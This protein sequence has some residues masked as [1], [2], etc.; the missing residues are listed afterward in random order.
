MNKKVLSLLIASGLM[1]SCL[2]GC[3]SSDGSAKTT[4][5]TTQESETPAEEAGS[6]GE[7]PT[8]EEDPYG[9]VSDEVVEIHMG[10][11][12]DPTA[13]YLEGDSIED[14][15]LIRYLEEKLNVDYVF[16]FVAETD[17]EQ[18]VA[19]AIASDSLPE[20]CMVNMIQFRELAEAGAIE[21]L[22]DAFNTYAS[23][24][25]R[26]LIDITEG[27][28]QDVVTVD[29]KI[30]GVAEMSQNKMSAVPITYIRK[31]WME[32]LGL[33]EPKTMADVVDI[34][35]AFM[36]KNPGG[37]VTD[38][39]IA[40]NEI[41]IANG[42]YR[43]NGFFDVFG[44]YPETWIPQDDGTV[45]W[46]GVTEETKAALANLAGLVE[47]GVLDGALAVRDDTQCQEMLY[48]GRAG[49]WCGS[50]WSNSVFADMYAQEGSAA[51]FAA[52]TMFGEDGKVTVA[53][54]RPFEENIIV[55]KK[56]ASED[57]KEA[58]I[59]TVNYETEIMRTD[60]YAVRN[61]LGLDVPFFHGCM[62]FQMTF[63]PYNLTY[64]TGQAAMDTLSGDMA[65]DEFYANYSAGSVFYEG[66]KYVEEVGGIVNAT[67]AAKTFGYTFSEPIFECIETQDDVSIFFPPAA[68]YGMTD[69]YAELWPQLEDMQDEFFLQ[70]ITGEVSI[71]E[72]DSFVEKWYAQGGEVITQEYNDLI[73]G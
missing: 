19:M 54:T 11:R 68:T 14:N 31:D 21:D 1:M 23:E 27:V 10:R 7:I 8:G 40:S 15:Y 44:S 64:I 38:G 67:D 35:R 18:K 53:A 60:G 6:T 59:K 33:E 36:E 12:E 56:G 20:V 28:A 16:D 24:E 45:V 73:S 51:E 25:V 57:V 32:E 71:D 42:S 9:P 46:G 39:I 62:P 48:N 17:Y 2:A 47:D 58:V 34:A 22:T 3:G 5:D 66:P 43:L 4:A 13:T 49:V 63:V 30:M 37:N 50:W 52:Y 61:E 55:V 72:F 41:V 29:G 70:V 69:S 65:P 26:N